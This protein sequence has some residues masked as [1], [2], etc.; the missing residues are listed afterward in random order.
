VTL[1]PSGEEELAMTLKTLVHMFAEP[2]CVYA[3]A[4]LAEVV[5]G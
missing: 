5:S 1:Q 3:L 4:K 2:W